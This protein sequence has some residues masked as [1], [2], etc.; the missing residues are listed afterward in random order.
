MHSTL[1]FFLSHDIHTK[2]PEIHQVLSVYFAK[3]NYN[4]FLEV[5]RQMQNGWKVQFKQGEDP[6]DILNTWESSL[7]CRG[8]ADSRNLYRFPFYPINNT[9][10]CSFSCHFENT[11][12]SFILNFAIDSFFGNCNSIIFSSRLHILLDED[13]LYCALVLDV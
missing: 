6:M 11:P 10:P 4:E 1:L 3:E 2:S 9:M 8:Q 12:I 13:L 5:Q 7:T